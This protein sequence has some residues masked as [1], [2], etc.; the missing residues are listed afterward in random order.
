LLP[1]NIY[2]P[3]AV[4]AP[5]IGALP[6]L[7][8]TG[9]SRL[10]SYALGDTLSLLQDRLLLTAGVRHQ[11]L[12]VTSFGSRYDESH[13]SPAAGALWKASQQLSLYANYIEGV[14]HG[15]S[16]PF[17]F[18]DSTGTQRFSANGGTLLPPGLARQKEVGAKYDGGRFGANVAAF[19]TTKPRF[20]IDATTG[21]GAS[22]G[23]DRHKGVE[24]S[25]F[26]EPVKRLRLL[27]GA[28]W[29]DTEQRDTGSTATEGKRVIG[30]P[31]FQATLGAEWEVPSVQGL[32]LEARAV[33]TGS[34]Y[35]DEAN[36]L[37]VPGWTRLDIGARYLLEVGGKLV[38][39][40]GR[41]DNVT[42]RNYWASVGGF[43]GSGYLVLG[44]PR[45]F[46]VSA[47]VDF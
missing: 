17:T 37:R 46:K 16:V 13:T 43:P 39:L 38:T 21:T 22:G 4:P 41:I 40:R 12:D 24:F 25:V 36:T 9:D 3:V 18:I 42:D 19:T 35:A 14:V 2:N 6:A 31:R 26:G 11:K 1:T 27:G 5:A 20:V 47:S 44:A 7:A 30:V 23:T 29:L 33:H 15:E 32:G 10:A 8:R 28:T 45:S 34:S